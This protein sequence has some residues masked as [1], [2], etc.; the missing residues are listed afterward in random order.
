M[1]IMHFLVLF[2]IIFIKAKANL[3]L[4]YKKKNAKTVPS[5]GAIW[6]ILSNISTMALKKAQY[7]M[8]D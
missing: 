8:P 1:Q 3:A 4:N 7:F 6:D 2:G 5:N